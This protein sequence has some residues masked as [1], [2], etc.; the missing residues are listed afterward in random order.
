MSL[1]DGF[2]L[3]FNP[4]YLVDKLFTFWM[5]GGDTTS[6][7]TTYTSNIPEWMKGEQKGLYE[8]TLRQLFTT[9]AE[10]NITG[11]RPYVPYSANPADYVAGFSP[12][13]EQAFKGIANLQV[14]DQFGAATD[15]A[16]AAGAGGLGSAQQ[17]YNYGAQGSQYGQLGAEY[18]AQG[19]GYGDL[20][21]QI[22]QMGLQAQ[23]LGQDI[24]AQ[25]Q[26]YAAQQAGAGQQYANQM[27]DAMAVE[28]YMSP[29]MQ[30]VIN[31]QKDAAIRDYN[32]QRTNRQATA[33]KSGAYGGSR[34]AIQEAEAERALNTQLQAIEAQ[35][36]Q[37]AYDKAIQS[38]QFG[39]TAGM[40]G[41]AGAQAG[42]GT[43]LQG[44]QL[45]LS[46]IGTALQ[47]LQGGMQGAGVGIQ[48]A[49]A[50]MQGAQVGLQGVSGAQAGYGL[51]NQS[52]GQLTN[53]GSAQNQAALD[54]LNAQL[55][56]G[57]QQQQQQQNIIN[58]AVGNYAQAQSYPQEQL[59]Y[60]MGMLSGMPSPGTVTQRYMPAANALGQLAGAGTALYGLSQM[61]Q[62]RAEGGI[63][64]L[65]KGGMVE[66]YAEGG[67]VTGPDN[68]E[69][70]AQSLSVQQLQQAMQNKTVPEYI[71]IPLLAQKQQEQQRMQ[72]AQA[73]MQ[74]QQGGQG[75]PTIKDRVMQGIEAL[76]SNLPAEGMAGGG[77]VAFG[78][79]GD[80]PGYAGP[81]GSL[82]QSPKRFRELT[83]EEFNQLVPYAK[84]QYLREYGAP[85]RSSAAERGAA[86]EKDMSLFE[87]I[88]QDR[89]R[90][91]AGVQPI[92]TPAQVQMPQAPAQTAPQAQ[93]AAE[94]PLTYERIDQAPAGPI[95]VG[96]PGVGGAIADVT[97]RFGEITPE[98][99]KVKTYEGKYAGKLGSA[100]EKIEQRANEEPMSFD[101]AM[102]QAERAYQ[103]KAFEAYEK[104]VNADLDKLSEREKDVTAKSFIKAGLGMM[105]AGQPKPGEP[106]PTLF[107][108]LAEG[109]NLGIDFNESQMRDID[110]ARQMHQRSL[111]DIEQAR[112]LEGQNKYKEAQ[113]LFERGQDRQDKAIDTVYNVYSG[114]NKD[115][116]TRFFKGVELGVQ[117]KVAES[118][119]ISDL[120][121]TGIREAGASQ[122]LGAQ[123]TA[124]RDLY[125]NYGKG[126]RGTGGAKGGFTDQQIEQ[127][128]DSLRSQA[129][130][131]V[132][133][134]PDIQRMG[135]AQRKKNQDLI[136]R[137]INEKLN[138]LVNQE[139]NS[140]QQSRVGSPIMLDYSALF[141]TR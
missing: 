76:P 119:E 97:K 120:Q 18:G 9:D 124:E 79:G 17:A 112:R 2:K 63:V 83:I 123:L 68:I 14:P 101:Q 77:I 66:S 117:A 89:G 24:S 73:A 58:Q 34:Q 106:T 45:G 122:R 31:M 134:S 74:Q 99:E 23:G 88:Q 13:Q 49:Q 125:K 5:S 132:E 32:V 133:S 72:M 57:G 39:T 7:G 126:I 98:I 6:T 70:I 53:I 46:G 33:A 107:S 10:G 87:K 86:Q 111:A 95:R 27:T 115:D 118:K 15:F 71:G 108:V 56:A 141:G 19:A 109:A 50:G 138:E 114:L 81:E 80:V 22:G 100:A 43:A 116:Q 90:R 29:Y 44:G 82:V 94:Q 48:G 130:T 47:G 85:T 128:R 110:K 41:L 127:L 12:L 40:Q 16:K 113:R 42:L 61:G 3:F 102:Q 64:K 26:A 11:V 69:R 55:G 67:D 105:I 129:K 54:I 121:Q 136:D 84:E 65:A 52:A 135:T 1:L 25:S 37:S 137:R 51:A 35:G 78:G 104:M 30:N 4:A 62:R 8:A 96:A 28:A 21:A 20:A 38:M 131:L 140:V 75:L 59:G 36:L 103:G 91:M 60:M 92:G 139:I 93:T